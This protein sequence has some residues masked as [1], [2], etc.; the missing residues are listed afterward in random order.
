MGDEIMPKLK[1][2]PYPALIVETAYH[3]S[4]P[5]AIRDM[6]EWLGPHTSVQV[7]IIIKIYKPY[8]DPEGSMSKMPSVR[9]EAAVFRRFEKG[10]QSTVE[11][12]RHIALI[13][14]H[15]TLFFFLPFLHLL[16]LVKLTLLV[17][18]IW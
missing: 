14:P 13:D 1:R 5:D 4:W 7:V 17:I 6:Q 16:T 9:M 3:E 10:I 18:L 15:F 11:V 8:A 2:V 12:V